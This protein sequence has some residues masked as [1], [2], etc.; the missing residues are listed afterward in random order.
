MHINI[1]CSSILTTISNVPHSEVASKK[2]RHMTCIRASRAWSKSKFQLC[3][4]HTCLL[5]VH[6]YHS[7]R[8]SIKIYALFNQPNNPENMTQYTRWAIHHHTRIHLP[9]NEKR[10]QNLSPK[11]SIHPSHNTAVLE[12]HELH[13]TPDERTLFFRAHQHPTITL[14]GTY[15]PPATKGNLDATFC[16][17]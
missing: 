14:A 16:S 1:H 10:V 5:P 17:S 12:E 7:K 11:I 6:S 15:T 8:S 4:V 9:V 3:C 2:E 13:S